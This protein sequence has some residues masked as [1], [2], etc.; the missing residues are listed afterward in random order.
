M[1]DQSNSEFIIFAAEVVFNKRLNSH[2]GCIGAAPSQKKTVIT[3]IHDLYL[4]FTPR[5]PRAYTLESQQ[6][7]PQHT[8]HATHKIKTKYT[9]LMKK[10]H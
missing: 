10:W 4:T 6:R 7:L 5:A 1:K 3:F 9:F 2:W 8:Q